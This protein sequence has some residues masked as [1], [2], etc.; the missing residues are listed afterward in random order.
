M[1]Q[2]NA[3]KYTIAW[4]KLAE[5]VGR[6]EKERAL[7]VYRLLSHSID[8]PAL[9]AQLGGDILLSFQDDSAQE[10]Y[11]TAAQLYKQN[12]QL[13][14]AAAVYEHL[15]TLSPD[16]HKYRMAVIELYSQLHIRS[17]VVEHALCV[18]ANLVRTHDGQEVKTLIESCTPFLDEANRA[19]LREKFICGMAEEDQLDQEIMQ[20]QIK[21]A[22]DEWL[23]VDDK[24]ELQQFL[25]KLE[26]IDKDLHAFA[27]GYL[28]QDG[29]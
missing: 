24:R 2:T 22:I 5:C 27:C 13:L 4:F 17:K 8:D 28:K 19:L 16:S 15:I 18:L 12:D 10:K 20:D 3:D 11:R 14:Q 23:I 21:K 26:V 1:K 7:G 9:I 6:G 25:S 29:A